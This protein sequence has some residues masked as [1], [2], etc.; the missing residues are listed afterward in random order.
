MQ[1]NN[2]LKEFLKDTYNERKNYNSILSKTKG[3]VYMK[4]KILN[5]AAVIVIIIG[6]G[7]FA[8]KIYAKILWNIDYK[9]YQEREI[10]REKIAINESTT[11]GYA[12]NLNMD[13][14]YKD[15]VGIKL[16]SF[17]LSS[18]YL[19]INL[20]IQLKENIS[21]ENTPELYKTLSYGF[22][23]Y[24]ENN[25]IYAISENSF[26]NKD[27][28]YWK[29]LYKELNINENLNNVLNDN[30]SHG[31]KNIKEKVAN[32]DIE[33]STIK[34]FPKSK[35]LF[36]RI[37]E[38]G[39]S[40]FKRNPPSYEFQEVSKNEW[41]FEIEI[42]ERFYQNSDIELKL[43]KDIKGVTLNKATLTD[44]GLSMIAKIDGLNE[45]ISKIRTEPN[46]GELLEDIIYI[47]DKNNNLFI[48]LDIGGNSQDE[49]KMKFGI[50]KDQL[51]NRLF[52]HINLND[53]HDVVELVK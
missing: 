15:D 30:E 2:I 9:K 53:I 5:I 36:I 51:K 34:G 28:T 6:I 44:T 18:D 1:E 49:Q 14:S 11:N 24:D 8:P 48:A 31:V 19:K 25:N 13:Y 32:A 20:D 17:M 33:L 38:I 43:S 3:G 27:L 29:K 10:S 46:A 4:K 7:I 12:E 41:Q 26:Q 42:S 47:T 16:N 37:F 45:Y 50:G 23:I 52:L 21:T 22:A 39:Y 35:K 40:S